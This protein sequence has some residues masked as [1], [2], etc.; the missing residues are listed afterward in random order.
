MKI[1]K[2]LIEQY[3]AILIE[4]SLPPIPPEEPTVQDMPNDDFMMSMGGPPRVPGLPRLPPDF[5]GGPL[6]DHLPSWL[7]GVKDIYEAY[8]RYLDRIPKQFRGIFDVRTIERFLLLGIL[9]TDLLFVPVLVFDSQTG[10]TI[11]KYFHFYRAPDGSIKYLDFYGNPMDIRD[12]D[13]LF[14]EFDK[15]FETESGGR[16]RLHPGYTNPNWH[17]LRPGDPG[18]DRYGPFIPPDS[19]TWPLHA[20]IGIGQNGQVVP[21]NGWDAWP[22]WIVPALV[23]PWLLTPWFQ[24][25]GGSVGQQ[26]QSPATAP[27]WQS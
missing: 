13:E 18:Y 3:K 17:N 15:Y 14:D 20:P 19:G 12:Q 10:Q 6:T 27:Y 8:Q 26:P 9:P 1:N 4:A 23:A 21:G 24:D 22:E 5:F 11:I 16:F 2:N 7:R 25:E